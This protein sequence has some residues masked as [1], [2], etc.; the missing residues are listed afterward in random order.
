MDK[1]EFKKVITPKKRLLNLNL[2]ETFRYKDLISLFVRRDFVSRYKQTFL[3]P[4]WSILQPLLTTIVFTIIFGN[5][6]GLT[7]AD[8]EGSFV[9]PAFLFYLSGSICWSYFAN[10][11]TSTSRTFI[12]NRTTMSKVYYPRLASPI[13]TMLSRLISFFIQFI[14]FAIIWLVYVLTGGTSI[15]IS[16]KLLLVPVVILQL[17]ILSLGVG[18]IIS[19]ITVKYR[20]LQMVVGFGLQ[21]WQ[22][23][24]P[25]AYGLALISINASGWVWLYMLNPVTPIITTFRYAVFGF[26][27]FNIVYYLISWGTTLLLLFL[28]LITFSRAERKFVDFV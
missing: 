24:S 8:T 28:G 1:K 20:D 2:K 3:G 21:L 6:A 16:L 19:A 7:I 11:I 12:T 18:L 5:L 22:Y 9:L 14:F 17:S 23:A 26:G 10:V 4:L 13:S 27:Y 15:E 25:I